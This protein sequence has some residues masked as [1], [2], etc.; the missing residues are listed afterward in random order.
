LIFLILII[1][2]L[3]ITELTAPPGCPRKKSQATVDY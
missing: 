2:L 3:N 1:H